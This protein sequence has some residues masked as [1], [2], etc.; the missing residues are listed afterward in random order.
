MSKDKVVYHPLVSHFKLTFKQCPTNKKIKKE[1]WE[2]LHASTIGSFM[3]AMACIKV[4][5]A[6]VVRV[7]S[8]FVFNPRKEHWTIIK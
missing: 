5:I 3:C 2:V 1:L 8:H 4:D 6:H 7:V